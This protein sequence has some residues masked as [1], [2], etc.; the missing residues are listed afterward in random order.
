MRCHTHEGYVY[1]GLGDSVQ[2]V[3]PLIEGIVF[4]LKS[5]FA[6]NADSSTEPMP[7]KKSQHSHSLHLTVIS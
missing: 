6:K 2:S 5:S 7:A 3:F 1:I 4:Q